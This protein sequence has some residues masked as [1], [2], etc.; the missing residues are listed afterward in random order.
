MRRL[1]LSLKNIIPGTVLLFLCMQLP[2]LGLA[3]YGFSFEIEKPKEFENRVLKS[4][5]PQKKFTAPRRF[6]QNTVTHYNYF[7]NANRKLNEVLS[8]A[9]DQFREDYTQLL[10]FYNYSLDVTAADSVELDSVA[11]KAQTGIVLHDLRNDWVDN[12]YLLWGASYYLQK[13]FDSAYLMFQF[14]NYAFATKEDDGYYLTIGS[15]RDGNS[16]TS[17]ST[18][19]KKGMLRRALSEPP[20]RNDAFIWQIRN[21]L[22]QD[23][24][25]EASSLIQALRQDSLFP[26]R[27]RNDLEEVQAYYFYKQQ[28]WDSA[29]VHLELALSNAGNL[30]ER[31][32]WEYLLGQLY[33][34]SKAFDKSAVF[35]DKAIGHSTDPILE[36]YARL[37]LVR[38]NRDDQENSID[39]NLSTL[40]K[41]ARRDKYVDY[42]DII[43][44]MAAQMELERGNFNGAL[45]L[46]EKS[47]RYTSNNSQQRNKAFLQLAELCFAQRLYRQSLQYYDSL[48]LNDR[49]LP[50]KESITARK[51]VLTRLVADLDILHRQDSLQKLA[52]LSEEERMD[53]VKKLLRQIRRQRG[54][55]EEAGSSTGRTRGNEEAA[56][57]L[58]GDD[59][60]GEWYFYN[61][62]LRQKGLADFKGRWGN[63]PNTDNWR[64]SAAQ[65]SGSVA[66]NIAGV[67]NKGAVGTLPAEEEITF[68]SLYA[69]IP[70]SEEMRKQSDD[71]VMNA[72]FRAGISFIQDLEDCQSGIDSLVALQARFPNFPKMD[73]VLFNLFYC[74]QKT[75]QGT[76]A[77]AVK[78]IMS[79]E[80]S[81]S[82]LA[83]IVTTGKDPQGKS[84]RDEATRTYEGIYDRFIEGQ[85]DE[86]I[87]QKK[88]ADSVYGRNYW[89]PQLLYIEAVYYIKQK[90]DSTALKVLDNI[91]QQFDGQP[92]ADKATVMR[93]V[94]SRRAEIEEELRNLVIVMPEEDS[95]QLVRSD[96]KPRL[97]AAKPALPDTLQQKA[98]DSTQVAKVETQPE[99]KLEKPQTALTDSS[100]IRS[101]RDTANQGRKPSDAIGN[102]VVRADADAYFYENTVPHYVVVVLNK[103]DPIFVNEARNAFFRYNRNTYFNKQMEARLS[104]LDG[105]NRLLLISP[106]ATADEALD[107]VDKTRPRTA[108]EILP[109]L[110]GGKYSFL[111]IS[112]RNLQLLQ[113]KKNLV[114]YQGFLNQQLPGR[115]P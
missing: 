82:N 108:T 32:R 60:K 39:K 104:D 87:R 27:L 17:I 114:D 43:Y 48:Q 2:A 1:N 9:K 13:Q 70:L 112:E 37:A 57:S 88:K 40:L 58:F 90:D 41:M 38:V 51:S 95:T 113:S 46:L 25:A 111:I 50:N 101:L 81:H 19:E 44:F 92:L 4:E 100:R 85:F 99:P 3:Q 75:G 83:A 45:P 69:N 28:N 63:R 8:R 89:T 33:E 80:Y 65:R 21:Y 98:I 29:A 30:Q 103:V 55:K 94:L 31:A 7:F 35:Y 64:R 93:D 102:P 16:P 49:N 91:I 115:F 107:Y 96:T 26:S 5:K 74:Y 42:R 47:T 78:K 84:R 14:I 15:A 20:S 6:L 67:D 22:A 110:K 59:Q 18:K 76:R 10:P 62:A 106:F 54:L 73:E 24:F 77:A 12:M 53:Y 97:P 105:E 71:S 72:L 52:A 79:E 34:E 66:N 23:Q 68:E 109:W 11:F 61:S 86:A 56:S 36:V